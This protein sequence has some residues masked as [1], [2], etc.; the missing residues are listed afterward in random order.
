MKFKS[1]PFIAAAAMLSLASCSSDEPAQNP[2][3]ETGTSYLNVSINLP[4]VDADGS[5]AEGDPY[6][7]QGNDHFDDGE[8]S[9]YA[10]N[11]AH[12]VIFQ[13]DS[14]AEAV[15]KNIYEMTTLKP[16]NQQ[17]TIGNV[18]TTAQTVQRINDAPADNLWV[19]IVLNDNDA[20]THFAKGTKFSNLTGVASDMDFTANGIFMTNAP[21][22]K[23]EKAQTLV[24]IAKEDIKSTQEAALG[25]TAINVFV[26]R[27]VAKVQVVDKNTAGTT[28]K[29]ENLP[30]DN[31]EGAAD[32]KNYTATITKWAIDLTN[33]KSYLVRNVSDFDSWKNLASKVTGAK[34]GTRFYS[35]SS[36]RI[37][38]AKDPNYNTYPAVGDLYSL[39]NDKNKDTKFTTDPG[40]YV[41][42]RENTF[43]V[44][45]QNRDETTRVILK[46]EFKAEGE[47]K[48]STFY[49]F[50][51]SNTIYNKEGLRNYI[52]SKAVEL[53]EDKKDQAKYFVDGTETVSK[54]RGKHKLSPA[55]VKYGETKETAVALSE[56]E[57]QILNDAF[58]SDAEG[59]NINTYLN[60]ECFYV[61]R[62]QHF[63]ETYT[64]WIP[65][66]AA[67]GTEDVDD[68]YLGRYGV[69]RNN[70]YSLE[71]SGIKSLG[72]PDVP[73]APSTPDDENNYYISVRCNVHSWAKR[74]QNVVL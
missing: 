74:V 46:A 5:R 44:A 42:C 16:W 41:Y 64:P 40:K 20:N 63:G 21:L 35:S 38:W 70:W 50:G 53:L 25:S 43:N 69:L 18:T 8:A 15:V 12:L 24:K 51:Q 59:K 6:E 29:I 3:S 17:T 34:T 65:G 14:E 71:V 36:E 45:H 52:I 33:N 2:G 22:Y 66:S 1:L 54:T 26:E 61:A 32:R 58:G 27:A 31:G 37:F 19:L 49:T 39:V 7:G 47:D 62:V 67:Y 9:E 68:N 56:T 55:D 23:N 72:K 11:K 28:N 48:A 30:F 13:G 10:V 4:S 57:I 60:G 73:E